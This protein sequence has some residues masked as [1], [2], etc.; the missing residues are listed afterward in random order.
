MLDLF[1]GAGGCAVGYHRAGFDVVGVDKSFQKN[2]PFEFRQADAFEYV[3]HNGHLFDVIHASPPCQGYSVTRHVHK[4]KHPLLLEDVRLMLQSTGKLWVI[5]NV[6][7]CPMINPALVCGLALGLGVKRHRL[8]EGSIP[9]WSTN[10]PS[11]HRG[12]Y[13]TV[14]GHDV[15]SKAGFLGWGTVFGGSAPKTRDNR[16]RLPFSLAK[17]AMGIDWMNRNELSQ[18]IPPAYTEFIGKQLLRFMENN[19]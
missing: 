19:P 15:F 8:F 14:V 18:A 13:L 6:P 17:L 2:Y 11:G 5:E 7:G 4:K 16:R 3:K 12:E 9:L 10:C 1:C